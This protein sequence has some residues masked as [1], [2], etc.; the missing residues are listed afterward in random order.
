MFDPDTVQLDIPTGALLAEIGLD[1]RSIGE[2]IAHDRAMRC[3]DRHSL[4]REA[5]P[6]GIAGPAPA[7]RRAAW[8]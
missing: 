2:A 8:S 4:P 7:Q 1:P 3:P 5:A 6:T